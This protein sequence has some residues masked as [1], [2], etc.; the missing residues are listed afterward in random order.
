[1]QR[2]AILRLAPEMP[3]PS[4]P[5]VPAIYTVCPLLSDNPALQIVLMA[6][7]FATRWKALGVGG[8]ERKREREAL[9]EGGGGNADMIFTINEAWKL[10]PFAKTW[11]NRVRCVVSRL[12][13]IAP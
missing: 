11:S 5:R 13:L 12:H 9:G 1:M 2:R 3:H 6:V 4:A 10:D 8:K 7:Y